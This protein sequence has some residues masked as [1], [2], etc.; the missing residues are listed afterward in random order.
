MYI[1]AV[2]FSILLMLSFHP[3]SRV[4]VTGKSEGRQAPAG[5]T[6]AQTN[7]TA[8]PSKQLFAVRGE[9][10]KIEN[11][12]KGTVSI[13]VRPARETATVTVIARDND[14]V[15]IAVARQKGA[16]LLGLLAGDDQRE[17]ERITAAELR[18]G[19]VVSVIYDPLS[20]NRVLEIYM[21]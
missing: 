6:A 13:T 1:H 17:N 10:T 5:Q 9:V 18:E 8:M 11:Q 12:S 7:Q 19:D 21:H 16:D 15:G 20:Q 2:R 14:I 4:G 3:V